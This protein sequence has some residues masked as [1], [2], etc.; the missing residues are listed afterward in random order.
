MLAT[1][2]EEHAKLIP[3][4]Q[5]DSQTFWDRTFNDPNDYMKIYKQ[6]IVYDLMEKEQIDEIRK[7]K[8]ASGYDKYCHS[9]NNLS[10][11]K[12]LAKKLKCI[13]TPVEDKQRWTA[14][15]LADQHGFDTIKTQF[16]ALDVKK[17]A[18]KEIKETAF[19]STLIQNNFSQK[20]LDAPDLRTLTRHSLDLL[21]RTLQKKIIIQVE[22]EDREIVNEFNRDVDG[23]IIIENALQTFTQA[24][25]IEPALYTEFKT[26]KEEGHEGADIALI[27]IGCFNEELRVRFAFRDN[28]IKI[29][30]QFNTPGEAAL[31]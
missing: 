2:E 10:L 1:N 17:L 31:K 27:K 18:Q 26:H 30:R 6:D 24:V 13:E 22:D 11:P 9:V 20:G 4:G 14:K 19:W 23:K 21:H 12:N 8:W 28:L 3:N 16:F 25:K 29:P 15:F 7:V 5:V